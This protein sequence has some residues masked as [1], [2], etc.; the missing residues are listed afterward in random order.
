MIHLSKQNIATKLHR[1][2][3]VIECID[4]LEILEIQ[5]DV[6]YIKQAQQI[7]YSKPD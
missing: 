2:E 4:N 7:F 3:N 1:V 5:I 6:S